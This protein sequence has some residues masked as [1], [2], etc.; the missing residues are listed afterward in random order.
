MKERNHSNVPLL[1][2][3]NT[4]KFLPDNHSPFRNQIIKSDKTFW[5]LY[6][7]AAFPRFEKAKPLNA[8]RVK[9][10]QPKAMGQYII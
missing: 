6:G 5:Q 4:G 10:V 1:I 3:F 7:V 9:D 2:H 8:E